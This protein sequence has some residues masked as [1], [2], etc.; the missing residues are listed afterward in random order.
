MLPE[1]PW[2]FMEK[3]VISVKNGE[4]SEIQWYVTMCVYIHMKKF[5]YRIS[6]TNHHNRLVCALINDNVYCSSPYCTVHG[7][8]N[9]SCIYMYM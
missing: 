8:H 3:S 6:D 4:V 2:E 1:D 7:N 9:E 5:S